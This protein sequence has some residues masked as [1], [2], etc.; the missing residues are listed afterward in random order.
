MG[1]LLSPAFCALVL[2][3]LAFKEKTPNAEHRTS[4]TEPSDFDVGRW[5]LSVGRFL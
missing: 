4:N 1:E 2:L 3:L 5:V